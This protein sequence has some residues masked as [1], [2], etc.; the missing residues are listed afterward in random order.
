MIT[1]SGTPYIENNADTYLLTHIQFNVGHI[2]C[3]LPL[4]AGIPCRLGYWGG[5]IN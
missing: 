5:H 4:Q 2:D 3:T 1:I